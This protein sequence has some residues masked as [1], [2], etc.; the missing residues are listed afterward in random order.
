MKFR[1]WGGDYLQ[2]NKNKIVISFLLD[3]NAYENTLKQYF[4]FYVVK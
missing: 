1:G 3:N 2:K 4:Q